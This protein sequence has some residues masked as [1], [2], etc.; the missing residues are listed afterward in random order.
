LPPGVKHHS[1]RFNTPEKFDDAFQRNKSYWLEKSKTIELTT[2]DT[3]FDAW[4]QWVTIQPVLRRI[5]GCSFLPDHDYGKG[6]KGW[7]DIWQ[8]LLSLILI[9]PEN[10]RSMLINNFSGVRIDG[11]NAT[12]IGS[13]PGE[14][15]ADRNAITR[16]W[17]DHGAWPF[18]TLLLYVHQTGD[19]DVLLQEA[20]YFRDAQLS[21]ASQ[22]DDTWRLKD[23]HFLKDKNGKTIKG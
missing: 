11:S 16:V 8:D 13:V 23:G 10:I 5:F 18:T 22:K 15:V 4:M 17:M 2:G 19:Y 14:F 9:E 1:H 21:R 12:I 3:A 6:G 7:R 20:T